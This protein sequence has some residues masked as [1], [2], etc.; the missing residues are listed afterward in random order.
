M[1]SQVTD[2]RPPRRPPAAAPG[3]PPL[4][5]RIR[6]QRLLGELVDGLRTGRPALAEIR[7]LPGT[8]RSALLEW[9]AHRAR[10]LGVH[11]AAAQ[12]SWEETGVRYGVVAQLRATPTPPAGPGRPAAPAT[13]DRTAELC[14]AARAAA[15]AHPLLIVV[16]DVQW[17]DPCSLRWLRAQARRLAGVPLMLLTARAG[18]GPTAPEERLEPGS[19]DG[20]RAVAH[21]TLTLG[22]LTP[23]DVGDLLA[24]AFGTPADPAFR[25]AAARSTDGNP[26]VLRAMV[27]R[28]ARHGRQPRADHLPHLAESAAEAVR[29]RAVRT[30]AA[31]PGDLRAVLRAVAVCAP[32]TGP[33]TIAALAGPTAA[34]TRRALELLAGTG[35]LTGGDRP[36]FREPTAARAVLA[37][38]SACDRE[39]L[40]ARA[41]EHAHHTAVPDGALAGMLTGARVLGAPWAV[42]VLRREAARHRAAGRP[43]EAARLLRR[44]LREPMAPHLRVRALTEL[45][46]AVL[47]SEPDAADRHLRQA[48]LSPADADAGPSWVRAA[49]LL[50]ARGDIAWTQPLIARALAGDRI[51]PAERAALRALYWL[52]AYSR[53]ET[54]HAL[55]RP[56]VPALAEHPDDPS[57]AAVAAWREA[58]LGRDIGRARHLARAALAPRAGHPAPLTP[59]VAACH[60]LVLTGDFAEAHAGLDAVLLRAEHADARAVA[61]S[62]ELIRALG[63]LHEGRPGEAS[64]ALDR[65]QEV[66]PP[67]CWHPFMSPAVV[68]LK[69]LAHLELGDTAGAERSLGL[70]RDGDGDGDAGGGIGWACLLYAR[71]RTRLAGGQRDAALADLLECGRLLLAQQAA[72]PALLPWRS[73][74]ARARGLDPHDREAAA[75]LA[76]ERRLALKW[77]APGP[78]ARAL[79]ATGNLAP[80]EPVRPGSAVPADWRF[81]QALSALATARLAGPDAVSPPP[82]G[83]SAPAA[84]APRTAPAR[85]PA[86]ERA[87][88][89]PPARPRA[90]REGL[91]G[92]EARVAALAARGQANR[93]IAAGLS[94]TPRTV[95]LHLTRV[96]RKLGING[97]PELAEALERLGKDT[98]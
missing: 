23:A 88:T 18:T 53:R 10:A 32:H 12:A 64:T 97:R 2:E 91:T 87:A 80:P 66:M 92:A 4:A 28:L 46:A 40:Y 65:A 90:A 50:L 86:P 7:G 93:A 30:L 9:A 48:L 13:A 5:G 75:L 51:R 21:H 34:G 14:R 61:G 29:E 94:V 6:E 35:L 78:V 31:L 37:G 71:G 24:A 17:A 39:E 79:Y 98:P 42:D 85:P 69:A 58:L 83:P 96:Y 1:Q 67:H 25:D 60:A 84:P 45:S 76:E 55:D 73:A 41:A 3:T 62:A 49:D 38:M 22:P 70:A 27:A 36:A 15:L 47:P 68:A 33:G 44:A 11:V 16:D 26:A 57:E 77:G 74:A 56:P 19:L 54:S 52:A 8:G 43:R 95:E 89:P 82:G 72:N 59:Q 81:R 20:G 63:L